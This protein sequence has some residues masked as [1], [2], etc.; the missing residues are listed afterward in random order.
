MRRRF[1]QNP[2][3]Y[4]CLLIFAKSEIGGLP[5]AA[6]LNCSSFEDKRKLVSFLSLRLLASQV[7]QAATFFPVQ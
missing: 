1:A 5:C 3:V 6:I 4:Y 2:I 7:S